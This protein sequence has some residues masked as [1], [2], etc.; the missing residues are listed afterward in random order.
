MQ[1]EEDHPRGQP[2]NKGQFVR[3]GDSDRKG[4]DSRSDINNLPAKRKIT[5][6]KQEYGVLRKEVMRKNAAQ[7]GKIKPENFAYTSNYFYI[8][9]TNGEDS[10]IALKQ[11]DIEKDRD[12]I[13]DWLALWG[14]RI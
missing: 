10:F 11:Y 1:N 3:S 12:L 14:E 4:Y 5:L 13:N 6:S 9:S 7:K 2:D 8:Y